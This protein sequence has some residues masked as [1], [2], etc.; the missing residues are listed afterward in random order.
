MDRTPD[1]EQHSAMPDPERAA[2]RS[3]AMLCRLGFGSQNS[4]IVVSAVAANCV[5][6]LRQIGVVETEWLE[7]LAAAAEA[8]VGPINPSQRIELESHHADGS[9][10]RAGR[11]AQD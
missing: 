4:W 2:R 7:Q 8:K 9:S 5:K 10:S 3:H 1:P 11:P 6:S